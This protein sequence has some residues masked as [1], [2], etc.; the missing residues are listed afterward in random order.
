MK[1]IGNEEKINSITLS[2]KSAKVNLIKHAKP[3]PDE[4]PMTFMP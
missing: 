3:L 1:V 4:N 2:H